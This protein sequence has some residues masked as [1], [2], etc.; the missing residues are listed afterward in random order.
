MAEHLTAAQVAERLGVKVETV[1]AYVSRGLLANV[2]TGDGSRFEPLD[3]EEFARGRRQVR[4]G[5]QASPLALQTSIAHIED[6][7]LLLRE[8]PIASLADLRFEDVVRWLWWDDDELDSGGP[9]RVDERDVQA[10]RAVVAALGPSAPLLD[11]ISVATIALSA[12]DPLRH[13]PGEVSAVGERLIAGV[14]AALGAEAG[15]WIA[16]TL[17]S[18]LG[19]AVPSELLNTALV[20]LIEHDLAISTLAAR[21]AASARASVYASVQAALGA[22]DSPL[23][24]TASASAARLLRRTGE[25]GAAPALAETL[26]QT[27]RPA[28]GFGHALY[29]DGDPRAR[30]LLARLRETGAALHAADELCALLLERTGQHPNI[31]LALAAMICAFGLQDDAGAAIF[32]VARMAGWIAHIS[33]EYRQPLLRLRPAGIHVAAR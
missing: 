30:L 26:S 4:R 19:G 18:A 2:R 14:V 8:R 12:S 3:V 9:F 23:H 13:A 1:Y 15:G 29:P 7:D 25:I 28:P 31:D 27:G 10:A 32:A 17:P 24:G 20:L 11:R 5:G 6:G 33:D 21:A 16:Q 22:L